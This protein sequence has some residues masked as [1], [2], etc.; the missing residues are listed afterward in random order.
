M[1]INISDVNHNQPTNPTNL[2]GGENRNALAL[3]GLAGALEETCYF[4]TVPFQE[5]SS[6]RV[7]SHNSLPNIDDNQ[8][9]VVYQNVVGTQVTV[10]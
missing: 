3:S 1:Q 10:D 9:A 2:C 7:L 5:K 6:S 8:L 4:S